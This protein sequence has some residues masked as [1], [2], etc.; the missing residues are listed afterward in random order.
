VAVSDKVHKAICIAYWPG[1]DVPIC[2]THLVKLQGLA[3][4]MGFPLR[5]S[6]LLEPGHDVFCTNCEN[7][8][9]TGNSSR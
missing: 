4:V 8:Q 7:E 3:S 2:A 6:S 5:T 1:K 9:K